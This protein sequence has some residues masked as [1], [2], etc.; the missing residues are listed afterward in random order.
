MVAKSR[1]E[2]VTRR[3]GIGRSSVKTQ[4]GEAV[5]RSLGHDHLEGGPLRLLRRVGRLSAKRMNERGT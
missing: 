3:G 4:L 1:L 5:G 2:V